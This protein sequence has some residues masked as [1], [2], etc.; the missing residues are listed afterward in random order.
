MSTIP[1]A[2]TTNIA[3]T[4]TVT[5]LDLHSIRKENPEVYEALCEST[6]E[7]L[8]DAFKEDPFHTW[9]AQGPPTRSF[10]LAFQRTWISYTRSLRGA[11]WV[12]V[13]QP[14]SHPLTTASVVVSVA[15]VFP[16]GY[17]IDIPPTVGAAGRILALILRAACAYPTAF[18]RYF[19][20]TGAATGKVKK[21]NVGGREHYRGFYYLHQLGTRSGQ[22]GKGLGRK[23]LQPVLAAADKEGKRVYLESSNTKN[24]PFYERLGFVRQETIMRYG[25]E[26]M[27]PMLRMPQG[28]GGQSAGK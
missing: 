19:V 28:Q 24:L 18:W 26:C 23:V 8:I 25:E 5:V 11:V 9:Y 2:P 20:V 27:T 16:P 17:Y 4:D 7:C 15:T 21:R 6:A 1:P 3:A 22:Q 14:P 13:D 12:V 10:E